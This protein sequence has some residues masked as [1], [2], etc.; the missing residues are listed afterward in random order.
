MNKEALM[1][2]RGFLQLPNLEKKRVVDVINQ[3]FDEITERELIR[4]DI[5]AR[6]NDLGVAEN[7]IE[8]KCCGRN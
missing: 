1:I 3:Y 2:V 8:C 7:G 6:F 5:E 4:S